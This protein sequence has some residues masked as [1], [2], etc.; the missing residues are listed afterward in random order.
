VE[1]VVITA[2]YNKHADLAIAA[3]EAG[4]HVFVDKSIATTIADARAITCAC[5]SA[6]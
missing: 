3:A 2:P 5:K 4:K 6:V 1:A